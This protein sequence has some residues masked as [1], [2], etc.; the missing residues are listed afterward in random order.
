MGLPNL[1][2]ISLPP[3]LDGEAYDLDKDSTMQR[4][5]TG[6]SSMTGDFILF[7]AH[8]LI[9]LVLFSWIYIAVQITCN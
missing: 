8:C 5:D 9:P 2:P 3:T 6:G 4:V 7:S 1:D